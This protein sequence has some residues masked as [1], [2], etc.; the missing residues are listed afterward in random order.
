MVDAQLVKTSTQ[1]CFWVFKLSRPQLG[2][3]VEIIACDG[4]FSDCSSNCLSDELLVVVVRRT[5]KESIATAGDCLFH[6]GWVP[7]CI[8][9]PV[10]SVANGGHFL[11]IVET[12]CA[13]ELGTSFSHLYDS[14]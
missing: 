3:D 2:N 11:A 12:H 5:V 7:L 10:G 14:D 6:D 1:G 8:S 9:E 4:T 13:W